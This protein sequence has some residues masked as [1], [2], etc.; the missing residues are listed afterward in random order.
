MPVNSTSASY[1]CFRRD[2]IDPP[3][4]CTQLFYLWHPDDKH[5]TAW[6]VLDY[7]DRK[8]DIITIFFLHS[9]LAEMAILYFRIPHN[10]L[11][12]PLL[13]PNVE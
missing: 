5:V 2:I 7:N 13:P 1:V 10:S 12:L 3:S 4:I 11:C 9:H 8:I 6:A